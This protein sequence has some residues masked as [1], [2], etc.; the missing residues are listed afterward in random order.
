MDEPGHQILRPLEPSVAGPIKKKLDDAREK[1][2]RS[3]G[4]DRPKAEQK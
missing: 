3:K 4:G 2:R 1:A